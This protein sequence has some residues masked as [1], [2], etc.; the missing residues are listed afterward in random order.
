MEQTPTIDA[1]LQLTE[2]LNE[3]LEFPVFTEEVRRITRRAKAF[4]DPL[5]REMKALCE[6]DFIQSRGVLVQDRHLTFFRN[7]Q[8]TS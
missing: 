8:N 3:T 1:V 7:T 5:S 4:I 2:L 6:F